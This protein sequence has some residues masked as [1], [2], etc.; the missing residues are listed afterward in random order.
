MFQINWKLKALLYKIFD[1]LKL[2]KTFYLIQKYITKRSK[3]KIN[4]IDKSWHFHS[5]N[6][7][8]KKIS[9]ILEIG[10]GKSLAQNIY[11]SYNFNNSIKQTVIDINEMLDYKLFNEASEQ[12]SNLLN[13][14]NKGVVENLDQLKQLYNINYKAPMKIEK[15][16]E[17]ENKFDMCISTTALEH[18][19]VSDLKNYLKELKTILSGETLI[20]SAID[21]SDHYSHTDSSISPLNY[22]K[23]T[24]LEWKKYNNSY[25]FQNRL[26]HQDYKKV[27]SELDFEILEAEK[28]P[29]LE[30][31]NFI[32]KDF[33]S[34]DKET[35]V[36]WAFFLIKAKQFN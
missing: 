17:N 28:G 22:L 14:K 36:G 26:R 27:F 30:K 31:P 8:K 5:K 33:D 32:S 10:A 25:L 19:S 9:K 16:K 12:V 24:E 2:K 3:V 29:Y 1:A 4:K 21:Y 11:I 35:F 23:F 13:L 20:S 15:L 6:I 7:E 18:F 34:N